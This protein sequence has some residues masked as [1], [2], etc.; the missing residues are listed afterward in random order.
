[1]S[2]VTV[3]QVNARAREQGLDRRSLHYDNLLT[4]YQYKL[5]YAKTQD[6]VTPGMNVLDWGC[7][8]GHY[9]FFLELLGARVTGFSLFD[10]PSLVDQSPT[11]R[12]VQGDLGEPVKLPFE[13]DAFEA[14][15]N[16]GVL[17][18]VHTTGGVDQDSLAELFRIVKPGGYFLTIHLPN[19]H[20][21]VEPFSRLTGTGENFHLFKYTGPQI[22]RMWAQAGFEVM[23]MKRYNFLPRNQLRKLPRFLLD[24]RVFM[25]SYNLLDDLL[26]ALFP[27]LCQNWHVIARKPG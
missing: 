25:G 4:Q 26:G 19:K 1:M 16:V 20:G 23:E 13:N 22:K 14:I 2:Y 18:L 3:E 6:L 5:C 9:S 27:G 24:S 21:W 7:G 17:Q 11:F 15:F 12:F 8:N 10:P